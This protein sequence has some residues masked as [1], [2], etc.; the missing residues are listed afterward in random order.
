MLQPK[1]GKIMEMR[2]CS[3]IWAWQL[4]YGTVFD[5]KKDHHFSVANF[6]SVSHVLSVSRT[7]FDI[8]VKVKNNQNKNKIQVGGEGL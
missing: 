3:G 6:H 8:K 4:R 7:K 5:H 2:Q 1:T